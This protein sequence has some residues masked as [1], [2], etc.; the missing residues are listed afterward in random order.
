MRT[1]PASLER[2]AASARQSRRA[3]GDAG[4]ESSVAALYEA[5]ALALTRLAYVMLGD[6]A[7]AEDAVQDAFFGLYRNWA[8]ITDPAMALPYLRKSV[9]NACRSVL[10]W[11]RLRASRSLHEPAVASAETAVLADEE[12]RSVLLAIRRLPARQRE[13]LVLRFYLLESEAEVAR[14]M[15]IRAST[16]RS[17][18][19]RALRALG[20][21]LGEDT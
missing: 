20:R 18:T 13:V 3:P 19:H 17:T 16:V 4:A 21:K 2:S 15:G 7:S 10:R 5:H 11:R 1:D 6:N 14:S 12:Q 9:I 8:R